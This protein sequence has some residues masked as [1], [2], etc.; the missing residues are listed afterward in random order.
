MFNRNSLTLS[1]RSDLPTQWSSTVFDRWNDAKSRI[2]RVFRVGSGMQEFIWDADPGC[3]SEYHFHG[4]DYLAARNILSADTPLSATKVGAAGTIASMSVLHGGMR[5]TTGGVANNNVLVQTG[6]SVG[7]S[8]VYNVSENIYLTVDFRFPAAGD[9][10]NARLIGGLYVDQNNYAGIRLDTGIGPN[11]Y[12]VTRNG[13]VE[14]A[15]ALGGPDTNW[16]RVYVYA[17]ATSCWLVIDGSATVTHTTNIPAAD[18]TLGVYIETLVGAAK[19][20]DVR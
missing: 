15:T 19:N 17:G 13:G 8:N 10:A 14:T 4:V 5:I 18:G 20:V 3:K 2:E 12:F 6:D 7:A 11:L 9:Y 16:H 1:P